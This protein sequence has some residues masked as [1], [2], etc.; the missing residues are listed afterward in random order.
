[1]F[2]NL[3]TIIFSVFAAFCN[4]RFRFLGKTK[5]RTYQRSI[6]IGLLTCFSKL[7]FINKRFRNFIG[8]HANTDHSE[9]LKIID[10]EILAFVYK[11]VVNLEKSHKILIVYKNYFN[12]TY[13]LNKWSRGSDSNRHVIAD[14]GF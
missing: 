14:S 7:N 11:R 4:I 5:S 13:C 2:T 10:M 3:N 9:H 8:S 1:M 12:I 6:M